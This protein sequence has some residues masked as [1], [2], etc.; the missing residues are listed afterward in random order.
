VKPGT[1]K[2]KGSSFER[3]IAKQLSL[4]LTQGRR[5]DVLWR[6]AMSGG[7]ATVAHRKGKNVRQCGDLCAVGPEGHEFCEKYFLELKHVKKLALDQFLVKGTGPLAGFWRI[8]KR[9]AFKHGRQPMIIAKQNG[10]PVVVLTETR[11]LPWAGPLIQA[12]G[13][14]I[15]MFEAWMRSNQPRPPK[16]VPRL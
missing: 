9:E 7:R 3:E 15:T 12:D 10:W 2:K 6:S 1:G 5:E 4:W 16:R 11:Q 8:A 13:V 14:D